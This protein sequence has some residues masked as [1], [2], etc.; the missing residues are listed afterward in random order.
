ML[1]A[2]DP[3]EGALGRVAQCGVFRQAIGLAQRHRR[4]GVAVHHLVAGVG[5][6]EQAVGLLLLDQPCQA[7]VD[8]PLVA[9]LLDM[10][11]PGAQQWQEGQARRGGVRVH[12]PTRRAGR[13]GANFVGCQAPAPIGTLV[14]LQPVETAFDG[15][16]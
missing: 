10:R 13:L 7:A 16:F 3:I 5:Q 4:D 6:V 8:R 1:A 2:R 9:A 14:S 11:V 15:R 12:S